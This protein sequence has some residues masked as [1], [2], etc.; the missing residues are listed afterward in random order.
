MQ[1]LWHGHT[2]TGRYSTD[3][4][5]GGGGGGSRHLIRDASLQRQSARWVVAPM[6]PWV[7]SKQ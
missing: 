4:G 5:Q 3:G 1:G 6:T 2:K 7:S